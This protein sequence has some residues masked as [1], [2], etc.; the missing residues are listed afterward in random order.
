MKTKRF[1]VFLTILVTLL[2]GYQVFAQQP[3][4][5]GGNYIPGLSPLSQ[6][7]YVGASPFNS[8]PPS[9]QQ[10][11]NSPGGHPGSPF[12]YSPLH[13]GSG[14]AIRE[15]AEVPAKS[16]SKRRRCEIATSVSPPV[17]PPV[18]TRPGIS[19]GIPIKD[20]LPGSSARDENAEQQSNIRY[21]PNGKVM[22]AGKFTNRVGGKLGDNGRRPIGTH[23]Y[24]E[25][26]SSIEAAFHEVSV[27]KNP[28]FRQL[29]QYGYSLF[30]SPTSTF[31]AVENVPVG[32]D[33]ILGPGDDLLLKIWG[34]M[35]AQI[36][37]TV[38]RNGEI[39]LPSAGP[40][41]VW[42]IGFSQI[43]DLI[44]QELSRYY[45]GFK[46]SVTMG[47]LRT[48]TVYV[49]GE[50]CQP[51][52]FT[53]SS[54]STVTN[55]LFAAGGPLKLGS[56]RTIELK[57]NGRTIGELDLYDF[58][59]RG[60]KNHDFR[61][62]SGDTVFIP[63]IG[64][65]V[66]IS[67]EVKRPAIYEVKE[68]TDVRKLIEMAG[69]HTPRSYLSRVQIIRVKPNAERVILDLD[70][71][72]VQ[73][74]GGDSDNI[75]VRSGDFVKIYRTDPR[76]YNVVRLDGAVKYPG[77]YQLKPKMRLS[78]LLPQGSLLPEAFPGRVE[79]ARLNGD[80]TTEIIVA[81]LRKAWKGDNTQDVFLNR[82]D[83]I[84]IKSDFK[85]PATV[86][87]S[88]EIVRPGTYRIKTGERL[89]SVLLRAGGF[90]EKAFLRG[91][92]FTRKSV[93]A[94]E[95]RRLDEFVTYQEQLL[96][97]DTSQKGDL[98]LRR[99]QLK[100]L[101]S[102][103]R[104]G[105]IVVHLDQPDIL[106][107]SP[108]DI[109]LFDRDTLEVSQKPATVLVMGSVRNPTA[110]LHWDQGDVGYYL[111]RAGGLTPDADEDQI[112]VIRA[113]GSAVAGFMKL[114]DVEAGDGIIVPPSIEKRMDKLP[115]I[116]AIAG[117]TGQLVLGLAGLLAIF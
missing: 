55:A 107:G 15:G 105:R 52:A 33:Y 9:N 87:L 73:G 102:K 79:I 99:E 44:R 61:L 89:S 34:S 47:R 2:M 64:A 68:G 111:N 27:F 60:D 91:A 106:A 53:L 25:S 6:S 42:G 35:D 75:L 36:V 116:S 72:K 62:Q 83:L 46:T 71:S 80:L 26:T 101:V 16:V 108:N 11:Y 69:G 17:R 58:L 10:G 84:S 117:I 90:T 38:D 63:P 4:E 48:I 8:I 97:A 20:S 67:G 88:G 32:P 115:L 1:L 76:I 59:L 112:Y 54:L 103:I 98:S 95:R 104:L 70:L 100:L 18:V 57:R 74:N 66:G 7:P 24:S 30:E 78:N 29:K 56:L 93:E 21:S 31:A 43:D 96:L 113:D 5:N 22:G 12:Y 49:V 39:K 37:L 23:V 110:V 109:V 65:A 86:K 51:G 92:V 45:R 82:M 114:R 13:S 14:M 94:A 3:F 41:R 81:D 77:E 85:V 28:G 40:V 19:Q 50:V